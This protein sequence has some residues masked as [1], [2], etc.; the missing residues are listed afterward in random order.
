MTGNGREEPPFIDRVTRIPRGVQSTLELRRGICPSL[1]LACRDGGHRFAYG[2]GGLH[3]GKCSLGVLGQAPLEH[4]ELLLLRDSDS[5]G[6]AHGGL[7]VRL[8]A[9]QSDG[10]VDGLHRIVLVVSHNYSLSWYPR[11]SRR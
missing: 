8:A 1:N 9:Q 4:D 3:D 10:L 11:L 6:L 5:A 7:K 2:M